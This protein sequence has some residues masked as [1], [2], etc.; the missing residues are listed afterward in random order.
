MAVAV[1]PATASPPAPDP[2]ASCR[3][4]LRAKPQDYESAYCFYTVASQPG[5]WDQG[6]RLFEELIRQQPD[7]LWLSLAFGHVLRD[8]DPDAAERLYRNAAEGFRSRGQPD[9][10]FLARSSLRNFLY[11]KGRV[12]EAN[13]QMARVA[14]LAGSIHDPVLKAQVWILEA[15]HIQ[16]GGGDLGVAYRL[17]KDAER[18]LFPDG[19]YR[20]Q[21]ICLTW[22][23]LVAFR[24]GRQDEAVELFTRLD[25]LARG[26]GDLQTQANAQYNLLNTLSMKEGLLPTPGA[27]QRMSTLA[28]RTLAAGLAVENQQVVLKTRQTIA[29]LLATDPARHDEAL[30]HV[31]AC[32]E[33]ARTLRQPLDESVC[34]W[35]Q[36]TVLQPR[37]PAAARA[38]QVRALRATEKA[39]SPVADAYSASRHMQFSWQT[40]PRAEAIRDSLAAID[41]IETLRSLQDDDESSAELLSNWTL[42]YYWLSGRLLQNAA[43]D[44]V[45]VAFSITERMRARSLLDALSRSRQRPD[46]ALPALATRRV[47]LQ[48]LSVVQRRLM[49]PTLAE[50]ARRDALALLEELESRERETE[51]QIA[52]A[53]RTRGARPSF[54]TLDALQAALGDDEVLLSFQVGIRE[55]YEGEFGGSAWLVV[56]TRRGRSV[57]EIPDRAHFGP[58]VPM[59]AGLLAARLGIEGI[60]AARLYNEVFGGALEALPTGVTR[61]IVIPDGPLLQLPFEVLRP[62]P[63]AAPIV[64]RYEI[65][66]APSATLWLH[67]RT[68]RAAPSARRALVLADPELGHPR[69]PESSERQALLQQGLRAGP[70]PQARWESRAIERHLGDVEAL[71]GVNASETVLKAHDPQRYAVLHFAAH[72]V[73]DEA[74][75]E[76]SAVL[77]SA[78]GDGED[79]LLQAREIQQLDLRG[80]IVVLSACETAAGPLLNGEG[81]LSLARAFFEAGARTVVGTRWPIRDQDAAVLFDRFYRQLAAGASLSESLARAQRDAI[82]DRTLAA[83]WSGV[84]LL[85]DGAAR[86]FATAVVLPSAA[87]R[88][89]VPL[90]A[91]LVLLAS[92]LFVAA[93]IHR[94]KRA[95]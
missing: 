1:A 12:E 65:V 30:R 62:S 56:L 38:A 81:M 17:L 16:D 61:L 47:L 22:L 43:P 31:N 51:R 45:A 26:Q 68:S 77:L 5:L 6:K 54:A 87:R 74:H 60:P 73:S 9:G 4:Q 35:R 86:P 52:L 91:L 7:N 27:R 58:I 93:R 21:R 13:A 44:D 59:F 69:E 92:A 63:D 33:L 46:P 25:A 90:A 66:M 72:A 50:D 24:M 34:E 76:R 89:A 19:P 11:P 36:A 55:T 53:A 83:A 32:V 23:G 67:W 40:K 84:I 94:A 41:A 85:G 71:I 28:E 18:A 75:P 70:L 88:I 48:Q 42:E 3:E 64:S 49:D 95:R 82:A 15:S 20:Q 57:Y 8:R 39:N 14:E 79:G 37:D 80:R 29:T 10:E 2:F 78:G